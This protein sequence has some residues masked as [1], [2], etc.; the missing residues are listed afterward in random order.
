MGETREAQSALRK[1]PGEAVEATQDLANAVRDEA[2]ELAETAGDK[3]T[4]LRDTLARAIRDKPYQA[5]GF[6]I[7]LGCVIGLVVA[8]RHR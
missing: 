4:E 1:L 7:G 6:A 3:V 5:L 2:L 8:R